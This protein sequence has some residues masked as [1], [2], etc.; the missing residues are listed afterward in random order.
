V[1]RAK[2][3]FIRA[4]EAPVFGRPVGGEMTVADL[5]TP[6]S[7]GYPTEY[8][9]RVEAWAQSVAEHRFLGN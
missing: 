3:R 4:P 2:E 6:G 7:L 1:D 8:P 5:G 9:S